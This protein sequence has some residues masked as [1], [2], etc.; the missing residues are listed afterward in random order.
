MKKII[1]LLTI[2]L[3]PLFTVD[4]YAADDLTTLR[5][6]YYRYNDTYTGFNMWVWENLP[7][8]RGGKQW[9]FNASNKGEFGVY[10]DIDLATEY[11]GA[12]R[13]GIIIKQ[14]GWDG[15][16]EIGGDRFIDL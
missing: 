9:D 6:H 10:Y 5:V 2:F 4:S 16:R 13:L 14:G 1:I 12:T 15:Y 11:P 3:L 8:A 7:M